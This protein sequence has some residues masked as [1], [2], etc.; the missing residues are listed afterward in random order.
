M[1]ALIA[2]FVIAAV[3]LPLALAKL[4]SDSDPNSMFGA[5]SPAVQYI[6]IVWEMF[7][8]IWLVSGKRLALSALASICTLSVFAGSI[9]FEL[10]RKSPRPCGCGGLI[11]FQATSS[12]SALY[13]G[14]F[15]NIAL[16]G[17]SAYLLTTVSKI[18]LPARLSA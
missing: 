6:V 15:L 2:R 1:K 4:V 9:A 17:L 13:A 3:F 11:L 12:V 8:A 16:M 7:L 14:L 10:S 5:Q 18:E